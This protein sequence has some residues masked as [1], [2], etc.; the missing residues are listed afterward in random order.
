MSIDKD[1]LKARLSEIYFT[2]NELQRLTSKPFNQLNVD[3]KYSMR[4]NII[5]L[6]ESIVSLC[7]HI[8]TEVYGKT[9][10]SYRDAVNIEKIRG[11]FQVEG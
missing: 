1:V 4:Y 9:P 11:V 6:A 7:M 3:G 10:T 5:V 2:M 8:S